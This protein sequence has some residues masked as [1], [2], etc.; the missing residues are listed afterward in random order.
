MRAGREQEAFFGPIIIT[1]PGT[2]DLA[3]ETPSGWTAPLVARNTTVGGPPA[4]VGQPGL[5]NGQA[6]Y[7][8]WA[9]RNV[10]TGPSGTVHDA[11]YL[12]GA[13]VHTGNAYYV[14]GGVGFE[15]RDRGP[16]NTGKY[17][18][19]AVWVELDSG[20]AAAEDDEEDN[21]YA[22]QF[23]FPP[24]EPV[25]DV[26]ANSATALPDPEVGHEYVPAGT[27][28]YPNC[29]GLRVTLC[30]IPDVIW[31]MPNDPDNRIVA[32][33][34]AYDINQTG[35][36]APLAEATNT[37][38]TPAAVIQNPLTSARFNYCVGLV[39]GQPAGPVGADVGYRYCR[40]Q[41]TLFAM[42]DTVTTRFLGTDCLDPT[43]CTTT[44]ARTPGSPSSWP[45]TTR[46]N[47]KLRIF[48][49][50]FDLGTLADAAAT[51]HVAQGDTSYY[52]VLLPPGQR[53]SRSSPGM[54]RRTSSAYY[55]IFAYSAKPDPAA[56]TPDG[57]FA[58]T[59]RRSARRTTRTRTTSRRPTALTGGSAATGIYWSL[60]N[61]SPDA[62]HPDRPAPRGDLDGS[63]LFGGIF[64]EPLLPGQEVKAVH[65]SLFTVRGGRHTLSHRVNSNGAIDEDDWTNNRHG[66]QW[67]WSSQTLAA[68][69][70]NTLPVPSN[71]FG[72]LTLITEGTVALN[73]DG[74]RPS[75]PVSPTTGPSSRR[76]RHGRR[77]STWTSAIFTS[78]PCRRA[79][80]TDLAMSQWS[81][82]GCDFVLRG[83]SGA[84]DDHVQ[85]RR[86]PR[87]RADQ[88][89]LHPGDPD[90][91]PTSGRIP[92][93]SGA[94]H[95]GGGQLPR[96]HRTWICRRARTASPC[97]APTSTSAS[98]CTTS[99][100]VSRPRPNPG[101]TASPGRPRT[102][103]SQDVSFVVEVP[104]IG[105][106]TDFALVV[107]RPDGH[108]GRPA[109]GDW[110]RHDR[111]RSSPASTTA[112]RRCRRSP[113][114]AWSAPRPTRSTR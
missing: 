33:L 60:K 19:H 58:N 24:L 4:P 12:D 94:R 110:Q 106:P 90:D 66:R 1:A 72:G 41:G 17:G 99:A 87:R 8:N 96:R 104:A 91:P 10:G 42:P 112:T 16:V 25:V 53:P 95:R 31:A 5:V 28:W 73:C 45:T 6:V 62:R 51:V 114:R 3:F 59:C 50:E 49:S 43:T 27:T 34:H 69:T 83:T 39:Q 54:L 89:Q 2:S 20:H 97:A 48:D 55:T 65:S 71:P 56:S 67:V 76:V 111:R 68:N 63:Y 77:A 108:L 35:F 21:F 92:S 79:Y 30:L 13:L 113:P 103:A 36:A 109:T 32:R 85:P 38:D 100:R 15:H 64:I 74:Y 75:T 14:A 81:G 40:E 18:R 101:R 80:T 78:A 105:A 44:S 47:C 23:V 7:F 86:H 29:M 98:R 82:P 107:W 9:G 26:I 22:K 61:E 37:A 70:V 52:N 93:A 46:L 11:V 57:W 84:R 88:R 102:S